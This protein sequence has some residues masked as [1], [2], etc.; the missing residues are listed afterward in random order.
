MPD[1]G[2]VPVHVIF[3]GSEYQPF[4]SGGR[5]AAP[6]PGIGGVLSYFSE[7]GALAEFPALSW[8]WP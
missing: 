4:A 2:S 5:T 3:T 1:I 7:N 8:H 6:D